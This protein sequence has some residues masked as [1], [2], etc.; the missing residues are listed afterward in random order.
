LASRRKTSFAIISNCRATIARRSQS[1]DP[2][3]ADS[4]LIP[5]FYHHK[6]AISV[7]ARPD[8]LDSF[9]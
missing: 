2:T 3:Q 1:V 6:F 5:A 8:Q 4:A 9:D 7:S